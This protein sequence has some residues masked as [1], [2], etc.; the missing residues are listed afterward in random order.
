MEPRPYHI[1][2]TYDVKE[3]AAILR[4]SEN[5]VRAAIKRGEIPGRQIGKKFAIPKRTFDDWLLRFEEKPR[6]V[7]PMKAWG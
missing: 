2:T 7:D 6:R 5:S 4:R 3:V 1:P